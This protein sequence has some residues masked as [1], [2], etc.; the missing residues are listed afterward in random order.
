MLRAG[1]QRRCLAKRDRDRGNHQRRRRGQIKQM[2]DAIRADMRRADRLTLGV[3]IDGDRPGA[4]AEDHLTG[5]I[6][7][8]AAR[9]GAVPGGQ[10]G[11]RK[12]QADIAS[13]RFHHR[14]VFQEAPSVSRQKRARR[15]AK[16]RGLRQVKDRRTRGVRRSE[17]LGSDC[18]IR[19]ACAYQA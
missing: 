18:K 19:Q 15:E 6:A 5:R 8:K 3:D 14:K 12:Q 2:G 1:G 4:G 16:R 10:Q 11:Q 17:I 13:E 9:G 7:R